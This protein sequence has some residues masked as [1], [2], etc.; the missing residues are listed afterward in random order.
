MLMTKVV[1]SSFCLFIGID[2][3][4]IVEERYIK[5]DSSDKEVYFIKVY[6]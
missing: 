2:R 3:E 6:N 4:I 1:M 5:E